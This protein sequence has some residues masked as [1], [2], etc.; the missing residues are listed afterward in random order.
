M[1]GSASDGLRNVRSKLG[2]GGG[3]GVLGMTKN[4]PSLARPAANPVFAAFS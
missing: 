3:R 4:P 1:G 2:G